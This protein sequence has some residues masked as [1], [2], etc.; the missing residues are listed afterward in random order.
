[1]RSHSTSIEKCI[2]SRGL[3]RIRPNDNRQLSI[4]RVSISPNV[5]VQAVFSV[6]KTC[7]ESELLRAHGSESA[8]IEG[9]IPC[10]A[11]L[12][13]AGAVYARGVSSE[14]NALPDSDVFPIRH[15]S[16]RRAVECSVALYGTIGGIDDLVVELCES[17]G[18]LETENGEPGVFNLDFHNEMNE[19]TQQKEERNE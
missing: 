9:G 7:L 3:S 6:G 14:W 18:G 8:G 17:T 4:S 1:M 19:K 12:G 10:S 2:G 13:S 15:V 16:D 11:V 5:Q